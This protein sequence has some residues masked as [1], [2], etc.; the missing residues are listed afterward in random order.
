MARGQLTAETSL[1][2][3]LVH[4]DPPIGTTRCRA[5]TV[6]GSRPQAEASSSSFWKAGVATRAALA[7][8]SSAARNSGV[9]S[10]AWNASLTRWSFQICLTVR[11]G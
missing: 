1:G 4:V 7:G 5:G 9:S 10:T 2:R 3:D 8:L 6:G 11:S